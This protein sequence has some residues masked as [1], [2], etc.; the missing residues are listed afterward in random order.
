MVKQ[1][2]GSEVI[3]YGDQAQ[4]MPSCAEIITV[5]KNG[6]PQVSKGGFESTPRARKMKPEP[7]PVETKLIPD[8]P[9][10]I[11]QA[12]AAPA[13]NAVA[14]PQGVRPTPKPK[15]AVPCIKNAASA[16]A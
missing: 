6:K 7:T 11:P 10:S 1:P 8:R 3:M 5:G 4:P 12:A 16:K 9:K 14:A 15:P 13:P 2:K